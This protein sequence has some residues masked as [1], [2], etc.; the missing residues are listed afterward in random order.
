M[1]VPSLLMS[2]TVM[3][4][5]YT[6]FDTTNIFYRRGIASNTVENPVQQFLSLRPLLNCTVSSEWNP[7]K[8]LVG[9]EVIKCTV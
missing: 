6:C 8:G 9:A 4:W 5:V 7:E 3:R 1:A 2:L